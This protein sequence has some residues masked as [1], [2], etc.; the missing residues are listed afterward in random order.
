MRISDL[1]PHPSLALIKVGPSSAKKVPDGS[2]QGAPGRA[3]GRMNHLAS[4]ISGGIFGAAGASSPARA[5]RVD[6][7]KSSFA[8]G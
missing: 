6:R 3:R 4:S 1:N 8:F 5:P 2:V 7:N